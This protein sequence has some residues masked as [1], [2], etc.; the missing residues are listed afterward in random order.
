MPAGTAAGDAA[1]GRTGMAKDAAVLVEDFLFD[2]GDDHLPGITVQG[3]GRF[4]EDQDLRTAGD[5]AGD[6]HALLLTSRELHRQDLTLVLQADDLEVFPG[7]DDGFAPVL[8]LQDQRDRHILGRGQARKE[9]EVL[10]HEADGVQPEISQLVIVHA[11]DVV[12][13][14]FHLAGVGPQDAGNHAESGGL[15]AA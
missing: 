2:E 14:D 12:A 8:L 10:E 7:L 5:G 9:M 13:F 4:V 6:R 15:P 3:G 1:K 11:P